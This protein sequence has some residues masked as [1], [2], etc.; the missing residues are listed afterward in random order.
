MSD[1]Q[2][3]PVNVK[4]AAKSAYVWGA[5]KS[6]EKIRNVSKNNNK[7]NTEPA[8]PI[9]TKFQ[10]VKKA[11]GKTKSVKFTNEA[12]SCKAGI[13][14]KEQFKRPAPV[15]PFRNKYR[16]R[17]KENQK[18]KPAQCYNVVDTF[19]G[20]GTSSNGSEQSVVQRSRNSVTVK[21]TNKN[22]LEANLVSD[23]ST[24]PK[25]RKLGKAGRRGNTSKWFFCN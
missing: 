14:G 22:F 7:Q 4:E 19:N 5:F 1:N 8:Y 23:G 15:R 9:R 24:N 10:S 13:S 2:F 20:A 12:T 11:D 21:P 6:G 3:K 25:P 18:L 17:T 16:P